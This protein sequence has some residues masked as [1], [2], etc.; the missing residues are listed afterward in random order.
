M[1]VSRPQTAERHLPLRALPGDHLRQPDR[2]RR[3]L[4]NAL[5]FHAIS[6]STD[7]RYEQA[8]YAALCNP[9][10]IAWRAA[11]ITAREFSEVDFAMRVPVRL[12]FPWEPGRP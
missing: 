5:A 1:A 7:I 4:S 9:G 11:P 10:N 3:A 2:P 8:Q 6:S 12:Q